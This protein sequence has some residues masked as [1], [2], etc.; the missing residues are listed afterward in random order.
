VHGI[1][2]LQLTPDL[3]GLAMF[4]DYEKTPLAQSPSQ[5]CLGALGRISVC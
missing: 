1:G 4:P 5:R 2:S 3:D